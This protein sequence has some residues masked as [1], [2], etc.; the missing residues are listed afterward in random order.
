MT[1]LLEPETV[2]TPL[3]K[4]MAVDEAKLTAVPEALVTVGVV[5][6]GLALAPPKVRF[7]DPV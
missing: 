1:P 3:E 7:C 4:E 5:L 6:L 2:A